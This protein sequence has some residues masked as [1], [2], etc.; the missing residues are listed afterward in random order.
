MVARSETGVE[1]TQMRKSNSQGG[2]GVERVGIK[3]PC[4]V[5][6]QDLM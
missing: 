4:V 1:L 5:M 6:W 2:A 3:E